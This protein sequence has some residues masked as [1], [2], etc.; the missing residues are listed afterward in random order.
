LMVV[1]AELDFVAGLP[2]ESSQDYYG[3]GHSYARVGCKVC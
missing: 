2:A 1:Q 3:H